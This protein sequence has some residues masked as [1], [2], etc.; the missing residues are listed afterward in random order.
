MAN[1][2]GGACT[3]EDGYRHLAQ[4]MVWHETRVRQNGPQDM[5]TYYRIFPLL[6]VSTMFAATAKSSEIEKEVARCAVIQGQ[7]ERLECY[8]DLAATFN[9]DRPQIGPIAVADTG[10]W[11]VR[12][13]SNPID[14]SKRVVISLIADQGLSRNHE[15]I[16][17]IARC[18]SNETE[19]Y[20]VWNDYLG[21][22]SSS[23]YQDWKYVTVRIGD[24]PA[25][26]QQWAVSTDSKATFAPD[27][28][29]NLLRK[30]AHATSFL[31]QVTPYSESPVTAIFDTRGMIAALR[32]LA[33]TCGWSLQD[34]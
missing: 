28:A 26:R 30:M 9:L 3:T 19:A 8:D 7:L 2:S 6:I 32:P 23:V 31:A 24:A 34:N 18:Q 21:D 17:F 15:S 5:F 10:K 29:G 27:W 11:N 4:S 33:E 16:T 14:D 25:E 22:D 13:D 1:P 12:V 20:I